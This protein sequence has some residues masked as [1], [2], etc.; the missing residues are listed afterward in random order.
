LLRE[1]LSLTPERRRTMGRNAR[2]L[3]EERFT[4]DA[5]AAGLLDVVAGRSGPDG[6]YSGW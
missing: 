3:F 6:V 1:W 2:A 4:V 5:M